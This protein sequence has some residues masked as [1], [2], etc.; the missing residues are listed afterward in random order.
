[1]HNII[2]RCHRKRLVVRVCARMYWCH[3]CV[4]QKCT[5]KRTIMPLTHTHP[6]TVVNTHAHTHFDFSFFVLFH[7]FSTSKRRHTAN[8]FYFYYCCIVTNT[9]Q[10]VFVLL[11]R[12]FCD[13]CCKICWSRVALNSTA[14]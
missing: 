13:A 12:V 6:R 14:R 8:A 3:I 2:A 10:I 4:M 1:M 7:F 11:F 9:Q 5:G